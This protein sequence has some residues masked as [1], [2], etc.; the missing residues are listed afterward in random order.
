MRHQD[1]QTLFSIVDKVS[2]CGV[3]SF[4][5]FVCGF[6][7]HITKNYI[8]VPK[9]FG[10]TVGKKCSSDPENLLKFL[11]AENLQKF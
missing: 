9:L 10:P 1:S 7:Q 3:N 4:C 8:L 6:S 5:Q 11:K 2:V